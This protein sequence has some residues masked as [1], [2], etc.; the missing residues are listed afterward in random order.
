VP[1]L[2][3]APPLYQTNHL[4]KNINI[5]G[6]WEGLVIK[7]EKL[8]FRTLRAEVSGVFAFDLPET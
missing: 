4:A 7:N 8:G 1:Q 6:G 5:R 2:L 3:L